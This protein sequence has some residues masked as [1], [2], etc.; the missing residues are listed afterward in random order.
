MG[1]GYAHQTPSKKIGF[2]ITYHRLKPSHKSSFEL[3][4]TAFFRKHTPEK[5][6]LTHPSEMRVL[7]KVEQWSQQYGVDVDIREDTCWL[8]SRKAF[9]HWAQSRK[10]LVM[11][12]FYREMR[13]KYGILMDG[14]K[15]VG[16]KWNYDKD[17]R[18][19]IKDASI[20]PNIMQCMPDDTT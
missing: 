14:K 17:N 3:V 8:C 16:G 19:V 9:T 13:K 18:K 20:V 10:T 6:I 11:E 7:E 5:I 12:F 4:L 1:R 15:P 2:S